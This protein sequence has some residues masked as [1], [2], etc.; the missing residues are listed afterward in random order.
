MRSLM[1]AS[2]AERTAR[3]YAPAMTREIVTPRLTLRPFEE[4]DWPVIHAVQTDPEHG[5]WVRG[6]NIEASEERSRAGAVRSAAHWDEGWGPYLL[7]YADAP[8]GYAGL[9]RSRLEET[10]EV[11]ALWGVVSSHHRKGFATEAMQ[12]VLRKGPPSGV[13]SIAAWT[14]PDNIP[15]RRLME[16]LGFRYEREAMYVDLIHVVYRL[17]P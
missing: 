14:L 13:E 15:S 11:E 3:R 4:T 7:Q 5:Y 8:V 16:R 1:R 10:D 2:I 9:R 6:P 12:A 17:R